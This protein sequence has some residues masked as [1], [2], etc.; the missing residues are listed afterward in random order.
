MDI[1]DS[2]FSNCE[3]L[4]SIEIP[5]TVT[6]IGDNAFS[7]CYSLETV[8]YTGNS[9]Q[10]DKIAIGTDN[11]MLTDSEIIYVGINQVIKAEVSVSDFISS[12]GDDFE[13]SVT[14]NG[15]T[16]A[17][18]KFVGTGMTVTVTH[19]ATS[20]V[21]TKTVAVRGDVN[22]DGAVKG[23]DYMKIKKS[24]SNTDLL[25][26]VYFEAGD[27][28]GDGFIKSADYIRIKSYFAGKYNLYA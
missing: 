28:N 19:K 8:F 11:E 14:K 10:W 25:S 17:S 20:R 6:T 9:A 5:Y 7:G 16:V 12:F 3:D 13:C 15:T 26:G 2:I 1:E 21:Y 24:I 18:D 22:G 23:A 4:I 27:V